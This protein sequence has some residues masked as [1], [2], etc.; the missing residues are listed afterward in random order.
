MTKKTWDQ[1]EPE[2]KIE[3]LRNDVVCL[4]KAL[5]EFSSDVDHLR[6]KVSEAIAN[7]DSLRTKVPPRD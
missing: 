6:S 5:R 7:L 2:E 1:L 3:E 4:F